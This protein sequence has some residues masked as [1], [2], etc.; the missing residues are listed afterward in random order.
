MIKEMLNLVIAELGVQPEAPTLHR[1]ERRV[2]DQ[3]GGEAHY[4]P[5]H[6]KVATIERVMAYGTGAP[7]SDVA[8]R[9]GVSVRT[10]QRVRKLYR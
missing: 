4:L 3:F 10:V 7:A 8:R 6:S 2:M 5:K 9:A 1:I